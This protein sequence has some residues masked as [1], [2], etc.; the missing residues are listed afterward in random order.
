MMFNKKTKEERKMLT[1]LLKSK[2]GYN[3]K[4]ITLIALVVKILIM[5]IL[6][7]ITIVNNNNFIITTIEEKILTAIS[8]IKE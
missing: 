4:A 5:L 6:E 1:K 8:N 7:V 3:E 2:K